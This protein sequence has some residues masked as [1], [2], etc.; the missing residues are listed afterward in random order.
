MDEYTL[1]VLLLDAA[2][3]K[4]H[5]IVIMAKDVKE[6]DECCQKD[7]IVMIFSFI[8]LPIPMF[9]EVIT[10]LTGIAQNARFCVVLGEL[11]TA[12]LTGFED[13]PELAL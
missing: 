12:V 8:L 13:D 4:I 10:A 11:G 9:G 2:A 7:L 3:T 6:A 1:P 5:Q